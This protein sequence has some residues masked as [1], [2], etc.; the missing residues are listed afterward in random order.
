M[1][2]TLCIIISIIFLWWIY[3]LYIS[4]YLHKQNIIDV[5]QIIGLSE[6]EAIEVLESNNLKYNYHF[7]RI[8]IDILYCISY[9]TI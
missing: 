9:K 4:P 7:F 3:Y 6:T 2:K 8:I 1:R 5:P